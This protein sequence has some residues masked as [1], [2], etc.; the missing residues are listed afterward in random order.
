MLNI[1]ETLCNAEKIGIIALLSALLCAVM[2]PVL[3]PLPLLCFLLLCF[4]APFFPEISFF[5]PII[6]RAQA[7]TE[8]IVLTFDDGPSPASTPA[9]LELLARYRLPATFFVIGKQA[10]EHPDLIE[11]I[12]AAGHSIGNHS[13]DHDYFLMLRSS[14]RIQQ[15]LH[16]TQEVLAHQGVRPLLFRPPVGITGPR[17]KKVLKQENLI[18]V[19]YS[20][21]AFDRG[22]RHIGGLSEKIISKLRPR[23]IIMLHDLPAFQKEDSELL[24]REFDRLFNML[25]TEHTVIP[26]EEILQRPVM[27]LGKGRN[28]PGT[29]C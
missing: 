19:N 16:K 18:A 24:R 7:G 10:A 27:R 6:S 15:D 9:L 11:Q 20:C 28:L 25:A 17:L 4:L 13:W 29:V 23:D 2:A 21:R 8:G 3:I 14:K 12:L 5:L 1:S 22:N 26:L